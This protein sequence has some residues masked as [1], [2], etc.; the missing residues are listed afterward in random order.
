M[1]GKSSFLDLKPSPM[2]HADSVS[3]L[4]STR[5]EFR[6]IHQCLAF[7]GQIHQFSM[8]YKKTRVL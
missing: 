5:D 6:S 4:T 3:F 1:L 7:R 2:I 8:V